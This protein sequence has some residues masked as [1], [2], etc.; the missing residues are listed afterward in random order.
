MKNNKIIKLFCPGRWLSWLEH[1]LV[2]QTVSSIP[3]T[4]GQGTSLECGLNPQLGCVWETT[5]CFSHINVFLS[6]S[7][8]T[9]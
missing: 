9:S 4:L 1:H 2:R 6:L 3:E 7:F 5:N 8:A